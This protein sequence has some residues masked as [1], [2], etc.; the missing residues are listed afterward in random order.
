ME[1]TYLRSAFGGVENAIKKNGWK[2]ESKIKQCSVVYP[3]FKIEI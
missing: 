2:P 1:K 3:V